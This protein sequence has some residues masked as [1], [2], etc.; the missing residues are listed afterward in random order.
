MTEGL[1]LITKI[2]GA[3]FFFVALVLYIGLLVFKTEKAVKAFFWWAVVGATIYLM[4]LASLGVYV[5]IS[6]CC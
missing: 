2:A 1:I 4:A 6:G 5:M 3:V